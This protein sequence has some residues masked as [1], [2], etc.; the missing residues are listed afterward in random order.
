[1][2]HDRQVLRFYAFFQ[3]S[4]PERAEENSRYRN[5]TITYH[6]ED[7]TI[8]IQEPRVE[9]SGIPQGSFLKRQQVMRDDGEGLVGPDM[10]RC[11]ENLSMLGR[12]FHITGCD[13]YTR[14]FMDQCGIDVGEDEAIKQ[15]LW[16]QSYRFRSTCEK[17]GLPLPRSAHEAKTLTKFQIGQPPPT[18]IEQFLLNDRKVLR[19]KAYWDDETLY[20]ARIYFIVHYYLA[21]NSVEINEAH[22]NNSGR[23]RYPV[24]MKRGPLYKKNTLA[25]LPA[26]LSP[27]PELYLPEDFV[28]GQHIDVWNRKVTLY[29]CDDFTRQFYQDYMGFDQWEGN[30]DVSDKPLKHKKLR[31]PPHNG[32]GLP[33]DSLQNCKMVRPK[34]PKADLVRLMTFSGEVLR[35]EAAMVNG[36]LEDSDRK[37]LI[38]LFPETDPIQVSV[39]ELQSRN[40]GHM[41]GKFRERKRLNNPETGRDFELRD[42]W[43]G[44]VITIAAQPLHITRADE[45]ALQFMES[46]PEEFPMADPHR[47]AQRVAPLAS[48]PHMRDEA[49]V[50]P[51]LMKELAAEHGVDLVDHEIITLLRRFAVSYDDT[52]P[53]ISGPKLFQAM[54]G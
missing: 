15:D 43:V 20:G 30:M 37:M 21:D 38:S 29:Y 16:Q 40:S 31:P 10:M 51:D 50:D 4:V 42:F 27:D 47:I 36:E 32:I 53:R 52:V 2:K 11:G 9:N 26:M 28:V 17:G 14:W 45:H 46:H 19:F 54:M 22:C 33:E 49:G 8:R 3:E 39:F 6:M 12:T 44:K 23:D 34:P 1:M 13:R 41:G 35:F 18:R 5:V 24:F 48:T 7:G 25:A